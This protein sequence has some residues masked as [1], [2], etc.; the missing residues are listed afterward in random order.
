MPEIVTNGVNDER[1]VN[2]MNEIGNISPLRETPSPIKNLRSSLSPQRRQSVGPNFPVNRVI[3]TSSIDRLHGNVCDKQSSS[4]SPSRQSFGS[5]GNES[6]TDSELHNLVKEGVKKKT[7][8]DSRSEASSKMGSLSNDKKLDRIRPATASGVVS[9]KLKK[10]SQS[11]L[12]L[13]FPSRSRPKGKSPPPKP[14]VDRKND[15]NPLGKQNTRVI[16]VKKTVGGRSL[17]QSHIENFTGSALDRP[18]LGLALLNQARNMISSGDNPMKALELSLQAMKLFERAAA[19]GKPSL[20]LA[21]CLHVTAAIYCS[22]GHFSE[23]IPIIERSIEIP[24]IEEDHQHAIAKFA[25]HMHLGDIYAMLGHLEKSIKCYTEGLKVQRKA[26]GETDPKVGETCRYVAEANFQALQF[27]EAE[28]LCQIALDIHRANGSPSSLEEAADRRLMGLI[29]EA[30]GKHEAALEHL[31]LASMA[32]VANGQHVE[33]A[34]VDCNI[35]DTYLSLARYDEAI[36]AYQRALAVYRTHK[37]ENHPSVGS[38]FVRLADLYCRTWKI[39]ESKSYCESALKIY[40]NP[41]PGVPPEEVASGFMNVSAIYESMNELEQ[42]LKL[43]HKALEILNEA[44]GQQNTIAGIEAQMGV[45]YYVLENYTESYNTFKNAVSKLRATGE[46]KS[47][48]FGTV[49]NQMGLACVQL[50]ALDEAVE[51]FEEA[52]VILEQENGPYHPETLGVYGNLAGTY[53]AI[54]RLDEAIEILEN[55]VVMREEKLGTAN[56]DVVDEKRRLDELLK[57]TGRVRNR[58]TKSLE[59]LFDANP[60]TIKNLVVEA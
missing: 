20:D 27:D 50:H 33:V 53:D 10:A 3:D 4:Q 13:E 11:Q 26:L 57:E 31:V 43:L 18:D 22:L 7:K 59:I 56:P 54:G 5:D 36:F 37:G 24:T 41:M 35:G 28:R 1:R 58:K 32:M 42:A 15:N 48:F 40:E 2:E 29:C 25:G 45:M 46:K 21:M 9:Q 52:R 23:A 55:I 14:P 8:G 34:S 17:S 12:A 16:R 60:R 19:Y 49:L 44:S 30:N 51:L 39:R 6:K 47:A 38:V